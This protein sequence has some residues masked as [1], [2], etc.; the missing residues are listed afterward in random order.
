MTNSFT[1][2]LPSEFAALTL[3]TVLQIYSNSLSG[4]IPSQL[5]LLS[6]LRAF[7]GS[8]NAFTSSVP[9]Q[10]GRLSMLESFSFYD[11]LFTGEIPSELGSLIRIEFINLKRNSIRGTLPTELGVLTTLTDL[12][13]SNN[14]IS[15]TIPS[16][17]GLNTNL[18]GLELDENKLTGTLPSQLAN[19]KKLHSL[20]LYDNY[21]SGSIPIEFNTFSKNFTIFCD[22]SGLISSLCA[23]RSI[24]QPA[25][26]FLSPIIFI[27]VVC[28]ICLLMIIIIISGILIFKYRATEVIRV[29]NYIFGII[30]V[31]GELILSSSVIPFGVT[32]IDVDIELRDIACIAYPHF[33]THGLVI[34]LSCVI[35]RCYPIWRLFNNRELKQIT[36]KSSDLAKAVF[37]AALISAGI[38]TPTTMDSRANK[39]TFGCYNTRDTSILI[40]LLG[41]YV[42]LLALI[43]CILGFKIRNVPEKFNNTHDIA[44]ATYTLLT[45][46]VGM[47][48]L[49]LISKSATTLFLGIFLAVLVSVGTFTIFVHIKKIH[50]AIFAEKDIA[51]R[52]PRSYRSPIYFMP[53]TK[54]TPDLVEL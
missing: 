46:G 44:K 52:P 33:L 13:L 45:F 29:S 39:E 37:C 23:I 47:S 3:L 6:N 26:E 19:L 49:G 12:Y 40:P 43:A 8:S 16:I 21:L 2:N 53:T 48:L 20:Y 10:L 28:L 31:C 7:H 35:A 9:S 42:I 5:C 15:G 30:S 32:L 34:V 27:F 14:Q 38:V 54:T 22:Y 4:P 24:P 41:L 18:F 11:N 17:L 25:V 51:V 1:G 36:I 50:H